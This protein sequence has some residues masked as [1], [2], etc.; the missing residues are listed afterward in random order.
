MRAVLLRCP[1][2]FGGF[3]P[4]DAVIRCSRC[5]ASHHKACWNE[6]HHCS[7]FACNGSILLTQHVPRWVD[8][9]PPLLLFV[10]VIYPNTLIFLQFLWF[11][12]MICCMWSAIRIFEK[13]RNPFPRNLL[14]LILNI[15]A[16][17]VNINH[18][19]NQ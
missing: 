4:G 11:P 17:T 6:N 19:V 10:F 15:S 16:I 14:P 2:C 12:A 3:D 8:Y 5:S 7:V 13:M 18:L 1:Y 9:V